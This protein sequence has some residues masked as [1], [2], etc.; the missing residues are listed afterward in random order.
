MTPPLPLERAE[1]VLSKKT[2]FSVSSYHNFLCGPLNLCRMHH[3]RNLRECYAQLKLTSKF[4]S[5][6]DLRNYVGLYGPGQMGC[7]G[8]LFWQPK[9][10]HSRNFS[11]NVGPELLQG[12]SS[13]QNRCALEWLCNVPKVLAKCAHLDRLLVSSLGPPQGCS[14]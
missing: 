7:H 12:E 1:V 13:A 11:R 10:Q 2:F 4:W 9:L 6:H 5:F 3:R 14:K 8:A